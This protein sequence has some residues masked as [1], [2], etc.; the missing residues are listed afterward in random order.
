MK[1][2]AAKDHILVYSKPDYSNMERIV[3]GSAKK[4][5]ACLKDGLLPRGLCPICGYENTLPDPPTNQF[6]L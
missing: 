1:T 2:K 5:V 4:C 6:T 3:F